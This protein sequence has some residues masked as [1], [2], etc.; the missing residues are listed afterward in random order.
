MR[1]DWLVGV[2]LLCCKS[3]C[4][5]HASNG[6]QPAP[7]ATA[8]DTSR[9]EIRVTGEGYHPSTVTVAAGRPTTLVFTRTEEQGCG[10]EVAFPSLS[11]RRLLPLNVPVEVTFTPTAG[12]IAFTCGMG[13]LRGSV[14]A[15]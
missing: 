5:R 12:T 15:Q 7:S 9:I 14:V 6:A 1:L 10:T 2:A 4:T 13:M 11:I 3:G 8:G